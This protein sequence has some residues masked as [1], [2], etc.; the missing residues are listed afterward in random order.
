M[1]ETPQE[2]RQKAFSVTRRGYDRSEVASFLASLASDLSSVDADAVRQKTFSVIR[3]GYDRAEVASYLARIALQLE[4][5]TGVA[6]ADLD[7]ELTDAVVAEEPPA[8]ETASDDAE[9]AG[10][11]LFASVIDEPKVLADADEDAEHD[12]FVAAMRDTSGDDPSLTDLRDEAEDEAGDDLDEV[13]EEILADEPI[14]PARVEPIG[15]DAAAEPVVA[16]EESEI[17]SDVEIAAEPDVVEEIAEEPAA[18]ALDDDTTDDEPV[19]DVEPVAAAV[20]AVPTASGPTI[21]TLPP[22]PDLPS[23]SAP[24]A[25]GMEPLSTSSRMSFDDDGF[26]Q[27]ATEISALMHQAHESSL[28]LRAQAEAEVRSSIEATEAELNERRR[29]QS[30]HLEAQRLQAE[31]QILAA[32]ADSDE[33]VAEMK[34]RADRYFAETKAEADVYAD[35]HRTQAD[36]DAKAL[37]AEAESYAKATTENADDYDRRTRADADSY[38]ARARAESETT[39]KRIIGE[40]ET[41][42]VELRGTA[43]RERADAKELLTQANKEAESTRS[44]ASDEAERIRR[45]AR[46]DALARSSD[47]LERSRTLVQSLASLEGESRRRLAEAQQAI[48]AALEATTITQL[49]DSELNAKID[50]LTDIAASV[51]DK[52]DAD[53]G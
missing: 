12:D 38:A 33:Y 9:P 30:E 4:G 20:E 7:P 21:P 1:N 32:R 26:Q 50:E 24:S 40:A 49:P 51:V 13:V 19:F 25:T 48:G 36:T 27:A 15:T 39:A 35:R 29:V 43:E 23:I 47:V 17:A 18:A 14:T 42:G 53:A 34:S 37:L 2:I 3:R 45:S 5:A 6:D 52:T 8:E 44:A 16:E 10:S 46:E 28:R 41:V 31:Q 22:L 11:D